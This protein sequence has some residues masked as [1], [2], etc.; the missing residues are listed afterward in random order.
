MV[1]WAAVGVIRSEQL[2]AMCTKVVHIARFGDARPM[3]AGA[4]D[5][6][7]GAHPQSARS[8]GASQVAFRSVPRPARSDAAA[9]VRVR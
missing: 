7:A 6:V 9:A 8:R 4:T 5:G 1:L 2:V 3:L